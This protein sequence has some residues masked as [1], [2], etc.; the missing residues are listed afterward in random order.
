M[1]L[2]PDTWPALGQAAA[3][4]GI[5]S[6]SFGL[7]GLLATAALWLERTARYH[8]NGVTR[9]KVRD[10]WFVIFACDDC[11]VSFSVKEEQYAG[12]PLCADCIHAFGA[13]S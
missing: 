12:V 9:L 3:W 1:N 7:I 13:T 6:A 2:I 11:G 5:V 10:T 8:H 4:F